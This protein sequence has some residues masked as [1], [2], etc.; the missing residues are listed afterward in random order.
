[1]RRRARGY[2]EI[3]AGIDGLLHLCH[4]QH[5]ACADHHVGQFALEHGQCFHCHRRAQGQLDGR[6]AAFK[7]GGADRAGLVE[8]VHGDNRQDACGGQQLFGAVLVLGN[9]HGVLF[10]NLVLSALTRA[11]GNRKWRFATAAGAA[12]CDFPF[13]CIGSRAATSV[14]R[15]SLIP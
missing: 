12:G 14:V 13:R 8:G 3:G 11:S 10:I 9:T 7:Q 1:M 4:G 15:E 2:Q 5:R 6:Q